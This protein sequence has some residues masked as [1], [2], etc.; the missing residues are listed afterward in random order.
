[1]MAK[2]SSM[3]LGIGAYLLEIGF[4]WADWITIIVADTVLTIVFLFPPETYSPTLLEWRTAYLR[5]M[6]DDPR[7]IVESYAG[8]GS[9]GR[10]LLANC[11]RPF[12][13]T[14]TELIIFV[15]SFYLTIIYIVLFTL[16]NGF[17]YI[18]SVTYRISDS[19]TSLIWAAL[20][21]GDFIA[22]ALIPIVYGWTKKVR[23][24]NGVTHS[25]VLWLCSCK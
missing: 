17:P 13:M 12:T 8:A 9:F 3:V 21:A 19:L 14:Y 25:K 22:V 11:S 2:Y 1:M 18:F 10:R 6:T 16:L 24:F 15:F 5:K 4:R 20:L 23:L 7:Y